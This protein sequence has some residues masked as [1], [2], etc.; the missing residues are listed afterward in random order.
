MLPSAL[1]VL[2][3]A[4]SGGEADYEAIYLCLILKIMLHKSCYI[5][6]CNITWFATAFIYI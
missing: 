5:N 6:N 4:D 3:K 1:T 2:F